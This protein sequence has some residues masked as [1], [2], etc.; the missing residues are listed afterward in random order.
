MK[1]CGCA[2]RVDDLLEVHG[3]FRH[4]QVGVVSGIVDQLRNLV[5]PQLQ[6]GA[7]S[8]QRAVA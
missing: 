7:L 1:R 8:L 6:A 3:D 4:L 5:Q 2:D